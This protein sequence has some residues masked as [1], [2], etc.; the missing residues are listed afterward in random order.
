[1][2]VPVVSNVTRFRKP[3]RLRCSIETLDEFKFGSP[4]DLPDLTTDHQRP[5]VVQRLFFSTSGTQAR[6]RGMRHVTINGKPIGPPPARQ[7][8]SRSAILI[9]SG[10]LIGTTVSQGHLT[11][12]S[13]YGFCAGIIGMISFFALDLAAQKRQTRVIRR[14]LAAADSTLATRL[15]RH[16]TCPPKPT[17][18]RRSFPVG[19]S[20]YLPV[21]V[22]YGG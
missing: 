9:L 14:R 3:G 6:Y 16:V 7:I 13:L 2:I 10:V 21:M 1:V 4:D 22:G 17:Q 12:V 20:S 11:G 8:I 18:R 15:H 19:E 5:T